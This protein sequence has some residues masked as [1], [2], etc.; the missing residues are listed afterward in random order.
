MASSAFLLELTGIPLLLLAP[1][2]LAGFLSG[3]WFFAIILAGEWEWGQSSGQGL[4]SR[5]RH[6]I[7]HV[8]RLIP[9]ILVFLSEQV[10]HSNA[11]LSRGCF[12]FLSSPWSLL[13]LLAT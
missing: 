12:P 10:S 13:L 3:V 5:M 7:V 1:L 4:G 11:S 9:Y 8:I 6:R 2:L